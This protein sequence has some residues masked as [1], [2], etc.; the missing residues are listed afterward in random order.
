MHKTEMHA[1]I[2]YFMNKGGKASEIHQDKLV[3]LR[4]STPS[5]TAMY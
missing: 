2:K 5:F 4:D 1:V 3:V